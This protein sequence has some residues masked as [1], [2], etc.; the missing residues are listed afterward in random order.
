M[1]FLPAKNARLVS[2]W[3]LLLGFLFSLKSQAQTPATYSLSGYIKDKSTGEALI[4]ATIFIPAISKGASTN[5]YGY[6]SIQLPAGTY[7]INAS[8][9]GFQ[10]QT[11]QVN[12]SKNTKLDIEL[13]ESEAM[14]SEV[15][16]TAER[17]GEQVKNI[18]M[19]VQ[20]LEMKAIQKLPALLGEVDVIRSLQLLPGVSSVGEGA[21]GFN[22]RGGAVDQN[23]IILDEA[24]VFNSS[25][26]GGLFSVF[27]PDA[28]KD[29]KL[30]KGGIPAQYGGRLSSVLD[31]R[32]KEGNNKRYQVDGG[33]GAIFSRFS[34]EGPIA[35]DKASFIVAG[36]RSYGDLFLQLSPEPDLRNTQLYFYDLTAKAN[37]TVNERS[38]VFVSGYFGQDVFGVPGFAINWGNTTGTVRWNYLFTDKLFMNLTGYVSN[39]N[40]GLGATTENQT[41]DW[42]SNIT[43]YSIKPEFT[44]YADN[45]NTLTFGFQSIYYNTMPG[46]IKGSTPT[47]NFEFSLAR[48]YGSENAVY[49]GNEQTVSER[50][51]M[52]YGLRYSWFYYLGPGESIRLGEPATP[53]TRAPVIPPPTVLGNNEIGATYGNFEPRFSIKY[54]LND[55]ASVKASYNRMAQYIQLISNTTAVTP[56]DVYTI[57][58]KNIPPQVADQVA[59]GYFQNLGPKADYEFSVE[60]YYKSFLN[61]TDYVPGADLLINPNLEAE[62][63]YGIGRAYGLELYFKKNTGA[64]TG[65]ISYT[66]GR[67][68]RNVNGLNNNEWYPS[69]FDRTH[70]LAV[71]GMYTLNEK[72]SFST[73]V[74]WFTG[75]PLTFP[76]SR[77]EY[78][79]LILPLIDDNRLNNYRVPDYF[80]IDLSAT[81]QISKRQEGGGKWWKN[82]E[83]NVV[84]SA[85]NV[86]GRRNPF[87]IFFRQDPQNLTRTQAIQF[88][89]FGTVIPAVTYNFSF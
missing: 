28:V 37:W 33:I 60:T 86:T 41:F 35:K 79:G 13:S 34:V 23:L 24:P 19:S 10:Q 64:F 47:A 30:Y 39:Y 6:Y 84:F 81:Y 48:K 69:R 85:Y 11:K 21:S 67:S 32:L 8:F 54:E 12:L 70:L 17:L 5:T 40:Y 83:S 87:G 52:Q 29:V 51:S 65:W 46:A 7:T 14:T 61:Q 42:R 18:E 26:V 82:Y 50:I 49:I 78:Q 68:E 31:V 77:I 15:E 89:V 2:Y 63:L 73:N 62:L 25:H 43:N 71:V 3:L 4:G 80:R 56:V 53:G 1:L 44:Y 58:T 66:L 88:S 55:N 72:W 9:V 74:S 59:F 75:I 45:N 16:V 36:R 20:K 22:V 27:N 76:N 57:A 38:R